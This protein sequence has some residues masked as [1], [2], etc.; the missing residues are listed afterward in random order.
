[1]R[2]ISDSTSS[3]SLQY[4]A[5]LFCKLQ[6]K[7]RLQKTSILDVACMIMVRIDLNASEVKAENFCRATI[8]FGFTLKD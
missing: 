5:F 2:A 4:V 7:G 8:K 3:V 6:Q 1:M